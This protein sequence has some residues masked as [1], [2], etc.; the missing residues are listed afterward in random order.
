[1]ARLQYTARVTTD[2]PTQEAAAQK[3]K[4][5]WHTVFQEP[6]V[7]RLTLANSPAHP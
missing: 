5:V 3:E 4:E 2:V 6:R 7:K 1:M